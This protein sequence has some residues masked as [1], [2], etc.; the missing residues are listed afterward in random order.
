MHQIQK[1]LDKQLLMEPNDKPLVTEHNKQAFHNMLT[2]IFVPTSF[3]TFIKYYFLRKD[4]TKQKISHLKDQ[5]SSWYKNLK[6][7]FH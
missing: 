3:P 2:E 6:T 5:Q 7:K 1:H 4:I